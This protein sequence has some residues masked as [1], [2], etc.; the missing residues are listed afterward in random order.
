MAFLASLYS[1]NE[2]SFRLTPRGR[3]LGI[4]GLLIGVGLAFGLFN[5]PLASS[6]ANSVDITKIEEAVPTDPRSPLWERAKEAE[7]ALSAQQI[8][9]P[10]GGTT[11]FV[12]VRVLED[13][14]NIGF[15]VSWEDDTRNDLTGNTPSDAAAIQLPME[16]AHIPYQCMGQ[17]TS[18]VNIWQW[19][20]A[21]EREA[22]DNMGALPQ[23]GAGVRNLAS[24]GICKA[25]ET[26]GIEPQVYSYHDGSM[27]H[28]IFMRALSKGDDDSAPLAPGINTAVAFAVWNGARG[29]TRG[30]K[31]V[32]TWNTLLHGA[33]ESG[34]AGGL[35]TLGIVIA[36]SAGVIAY[37]M[38]RLAQ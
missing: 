3:A 34:G 25:A 24:N 2:R 36:V 20:A 13:G 33:P 21:L 31:A 14:T 28:V 26:P 22:L 9:Q 10:G 38:R 8:Y 35:V 7:I 11:R 37:S 30:M 15:R 32:S 23:E 17:S 5:V 6:A 19:K 4:V 18:R 12:R 1:M 16:P 27:W 29:E